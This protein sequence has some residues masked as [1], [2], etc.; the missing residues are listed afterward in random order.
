MVSS[1]SSC[2]NFAN[3]SL[4][5]GRFYNTT[6]TVFAA[7]VIVVYIMTEASE[8]ETEPLLRLVGM[9][10]EIL[11]TMDECVVAL[12]ASRLLQRATEKARRKF[13]REAEASPMA[14]A[15]A[16]EATESMLH[17][18]HYWGPLNLIDADMDLDFSFQVDNMNGTDSIF[19]PL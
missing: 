2:D 13:S 12:K 11:E 19:G 7:S 1:S 14:A 17:L 4:T 16:V 9:A 18:N 8:G 3:P 15:A 5:D 6:Y 10:I